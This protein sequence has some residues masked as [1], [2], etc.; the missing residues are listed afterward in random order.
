VPDGAL[1]DR[2]LFAGDG[3]ERYLLLLPAHA[4]RLAAALR[5]RR[6]GDEAA[7]AA[8]AAR[9]EAL[10]ARCGREPGLRVAWL[11]EL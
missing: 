9:L 4:A 10:A 1:F 11:L 5:G 8:A 6:G 3:P 2:D 7:R